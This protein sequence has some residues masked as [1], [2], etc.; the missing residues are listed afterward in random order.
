MIM[1][2][3]CTSPFNTSK[4]VLK[5]KNREIFQILF[6][7]IYSIMISIVI[8]V[9][10]SV[11]SNYVIT[12]YVSTVYAVCIYRMEIFIETFECVVLVMSL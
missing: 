9:V 2:F 5:C 10:K 1:H 6:S 11:N 3:L 12:L 7:S 4:K 8:Y